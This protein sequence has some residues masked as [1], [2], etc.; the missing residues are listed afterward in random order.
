MNSKNF[1][2]ASDFFDEILPN[3]LKHTHAYLN[4]TGPY[5]K[6]ISDYYNNSK[7]P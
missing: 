2:K 1:K 7:Q 3:S 5:T 6:H 4:A